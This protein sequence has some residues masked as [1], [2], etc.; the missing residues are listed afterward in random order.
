MVIHQLQEEFGELV[1]TLEPGRIMGEA[2]LA[3]ASGRR[4]ASIMLPDGGTVF[5]LSRFAF[6][7][8]VGETTF[9][10]QPRLL[11]ASWRRRP[12]IDVR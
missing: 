3:R 5:R 6:H 8:S 12:F 2:A 7:A 9:P 11:S 1:A 10:L 4:D